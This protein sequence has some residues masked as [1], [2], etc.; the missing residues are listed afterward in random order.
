MARPRLS[1]AFK[2]GCCAMTLALAACSTAPVQPSSSSASQGLQTRHYAGRLAVVLHQDTPRLLSSSFELN[3]L[4]GQ[5]VL[6]LI[7]PL[8]ITLGTMRWDATS[9]ALEGMGRSESYDS[10][11]A[12]TI[13]RTGAALPMDAIF[14]WLAGQSYSQPG[15]TV[16]QS[17]LH[18]GRLS[19]KRTSPA[20]AVDLTMI[21]D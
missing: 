21:L 8:G 18:Q 2:L 19:A 13:K 1:H 3:G 11:E 14:A 4:P 17:Q 15:W 5:G 7:G 9:A 20:P 12:L 10:I 6:K 16:D